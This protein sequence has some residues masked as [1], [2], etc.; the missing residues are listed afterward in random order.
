MD[1]RC[2]IDTVK[3][4]IKLNEYTRIHYSNRRETN[5]F[6]KIFESTYIDGV[7]DHLKKKEGIFVSFLIKDFI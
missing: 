5:S 3:G 1:K 2:P 4:S 7:K 6:F